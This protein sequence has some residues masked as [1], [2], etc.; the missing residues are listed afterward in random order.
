MIELRDITGGYNKKAIV[1]PVNISFAKGEVSVLVGPNGC[2]KSTLLKIA[3]GQLLPYSGRVFMGGAAIDSMKSKEMAR[4]MAYLPQNR[5][6]SGIIV[7]SLVLHGRFPYVGYPRRYGKDDIKAAN[8]AMEAIGI[9][10]LA[11]RSMSEL[12]GGERQKVYL[13]MLLAQGGDIIL[14]DEPTTFLDISHQIEVMNIITELKGLGKT[15]IVVLHDLNMAMRFADRMYIMSNG[16]IQEDGSPEE[17]YKSGVLERVFDVK[18]GCY[19]TECY[20][21]QYYFI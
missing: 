2:G 14:M 13:S 18:T 9:L 16:K 21:M 7:K 19:S 3:S 4:H 10:H 11:E 1:G 8:A 12:S 5:V 15:I 20:G 6:M 17:I